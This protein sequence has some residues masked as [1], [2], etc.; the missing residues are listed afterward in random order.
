VKQ[1]LVVQT[2]SSPRDPIDP[3]VDLVDLRL[4]L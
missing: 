1:R 4:D 2:L 3:R